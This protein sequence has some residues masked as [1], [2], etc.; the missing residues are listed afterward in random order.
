ML[1]CVVLQLSQCQDRMMDMEKT[2]ENP[3]DPTR[4][5][6]LEGRDLTPAQMHSKLEEVGK[7]I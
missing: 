5:R 7:I 2:L 4:V 3:N 6:L 1:E